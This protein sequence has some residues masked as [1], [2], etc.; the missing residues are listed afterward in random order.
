MTRDFY[1]LF[2]KRLALETA[3][4]LSELLGVERMVAVGNHIHVYQ[5]WRYWRKKKGS[6]YADY[7]AF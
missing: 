5:S 3:C 7:D 2:P 6:F 1:R 4:R